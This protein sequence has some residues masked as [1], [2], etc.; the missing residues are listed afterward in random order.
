MGVLAVGAS[1]RLLLDEKKGGKKYQAAAVGVQ[2]EVEDIRSELV[3]LLRTLNTT[4]AGILGAEHE[5]Q[6]KVCFIHVHVHGWRK[7]S[8]PSPIGKRP[9][10]LGKR[11]GG[12]GK[13]PGGL[14]SQAEL[15]GQH[16]AKP[17]GDFLWSKGC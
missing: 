11:P 6:K 12:L 5:L 16:V 8:T 3:K 13:R 2:Q 9:G 17:R 14:A 1:T 15:P 4:N 7:R 10:G